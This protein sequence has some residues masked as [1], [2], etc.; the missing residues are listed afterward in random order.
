MQSF[1]SFGSQLSLPTLESKACNDSRLK[2]GRFWVLGRDCLPSGDTH[3]EK[4]QRVE[5]KCEAMEE[6]CVCP[7]KMIRQGLTDI[8]PFKVLNEPSIWVGVESLKEACFFWFSELR[9]KLMPKLQAR[10][11]PLTNLA[12]Y[13]HVGTMKYA[14]RDITTVMIPSMMK[15][16]W[17]C[18][19]SKVGSSIGKDLPLPAL[20]AANTIHLPYGES[21]DTT[22]STCKCCTSEE[23]SYSPA[24]FMSSIIYWKHVDNTRKQASFGDTKHC[25]TND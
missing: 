12:L 2:D 10:G 9:K 17:R 6:E 25:Q 8:N 22:K 16:L 19:Q 24:S 21:K 23:D 7:N 5:D 15:I 13:G 1:H 11:S 20:M 14:K 4:T 3:Q 18:C